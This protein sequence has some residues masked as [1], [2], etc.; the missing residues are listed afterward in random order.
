MIN[1]TKFIAN[2]T[3]YRNYLHQPNYWCKPP[4]ATFS[5]TKLLRLFVI[6]YKNHGNFIYD[7]EVKR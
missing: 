4:V 2:I 3:R 6:H 5:K 1:D 7:I